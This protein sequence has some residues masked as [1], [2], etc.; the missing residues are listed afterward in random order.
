MIKFS[1]LFLVVLF[2]A[3]IS[4]GQLVINEASN[5]NLTQVQDSEGEY[6]DWIE[7]YNSSENEINLESWTLS[8]SK[9]DLFK[10]QLGNKTIDANGFLLVH[11]SGKDFK[12]FNETTYWRGIV[13]PIDTFTY[14]IPNESTPS[15]W[16]FLSFDDSNWEKGRA[17]FGYDDD[18]DET[19][20]PTGTI[21]VYVRKE[22]TLTE[23]DIIIDAVLHV[24]YDDSFIAYLNGVEIARS[25]INGTPSWN[26]FASGNHEA[27]MYS[28]GQPEGFDIDLDVLKASLQK[29]TNVLSI[30]VHNINYDSS[31]LTIIP[32]LSFGFSSINSNFQEAPEW[33][34]QV[35]DGDELHA[36]FKLSSNG[37]K[38]YLAKSGI[39][40]DSLNVKKMHLNHS[41]GRVTDGATEIAYF[42]NATPG[43]S[44]NTS[45]GFLKGY[46]K[47]PD[48]NLKAG[49][50]DSS[51]E[52]V[53]T[54]EE[55]NAK[56]RYST[57]GSDPDENSSLYSNPISISTTRCIK[58][59]AFVDG[60]LPSKVET[61]SY[62]INEEYELPV[63][64][65]STD[66]S[67][68]YG[69]DGIFSNINDT[70]DIPSYVEYF[71]KNKKLAFSQF[72]GMQVDGGA[73]GSR[74]REQ[75]SFRIEPRNGTFG[76]GDLE[77]RL[78]HRRPNRK[79]YP[80]FYVRNGSNQY[81]ILPY[82]DA[83]EVTGLGKNTYTYYSAYEPAVV[84]INGKFFGV[85]ELRE[86]INDDYLEDNYQM[87]I[88]SLDFLGVSYFKSIQKGESPQLEAIK[89]SID[90]FLE[91]FSRFESFDAQSE[92]YLTQVS[93]F[94]DLESY[95]DYI[96]AE[97]WVGNNDWPNNNIKLFR[98][99]STDFKWRWAINDLEWS[100][101][102]NGWTTSSF[103][104]ISFMLGF[105]TSNYYTGFWYNMMQNEEYRA[106]F[107]NRFAD[108]MNTNYLSAN[109]LDLEQ[110]MFDEIYPEMD[111][112]FQRWGNSNVT[113]QLNDFTNNHNTFQSELGKRSSYVRGDLRSHFDLSKNVNVILNVEPE[114]AGSIQ[115]STVTPDIYPWKGI[116]FSDVPVDIQAISN[117][118][119]EFS[120][121]DDANFVDDI[122][123]AELSNEFQNS[124]VELTAHFTEVDN[125]DKG[126]V[127]SEINYKSSDELKSP[128]WIEL[129]N[130]SQ[131]EVNLKDW[132]FT[133][134]DTSH[135]FV[136]TNDIILVPNQRLVVSNDNELLHQLYPNV[137]IQTNDFKF[138]LGTPND[139]VRLYNSNDEMVFNVS[140][141]DNY[142][143]ALSSDNS[144]RT[145]ELKSANGEYSHS[146]AWH[147]GCVGGSP[148]IVYQ[149]CHEFNVSAPNVVLNEL[150]FNAY[151][152]PAKDQITVD[153][154]IEDDVQF[155][156]LKLYNLLGDELQTIDIDAWNKGHQQ[157]LVDLSAIYDNML[158]LKLTSNNNEK[159]I[160]VMKLN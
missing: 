5:K 66:N 136:F 36:N 27:V 7:I 124:R 85:Y 1:F 55:A 75:H 160:K 91:D 113:A 87:K 143:W 157:I 34:S 40:I 83:L 47:K 76:D 125:F 59:R 114:G 41:I 73:G 116:Y 139:G 150:D 95:T 17:G 57:T 158:I 44:N 33:L 123:A 62:L 4:V 93:E 9:G 141:S 90:P 32:Y 24:D 53:L 130:L 65:V 103:D 64:S 133:D 22:F 35:I 107:I 48:F 45:E 56:I 89:G 153:V 63:L 26:T 51:I 137:S 16:N 37:E 145:L 25:N 135:V 71:D 110:G 3:S 77:Y 104:H 21:S 121:W 120:H 74:S 156:E 101:N 138:G 105:G 6:N 38:I 52:L 23:S 20:V 147:R 142:P 39:L 98:C 100:L 69:N 8:D 10:W 67:N 108:L 112:Q 31:D 96:I 151:P 117:L 29:G 106:Y 127:I 88:D 54:C 149:A 119:Y 159:T 61:A 11:A 28:G 140:Y 102:P 14:L 19:I 155:C 81:N 78:L 148:E 115:I 128:D 109:L 94:L 97:S 18:D 82:K 146:S 80:S 144:G 118:G 30:E 126:I 68:L 70:W 86:K 131:D 92:N 134:D 72:A 46:A 122:Y 79:N 129:C 132:Y 49:Y 60:K 13:V 99:E 12:A 152:N 84:L 58:T 42:I 15:T 43:S 2:S 154:L 50:Y 111:S